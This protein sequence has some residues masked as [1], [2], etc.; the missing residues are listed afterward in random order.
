LRLGRPSDGESHPANAALHIVACRSFVETMLS[1]TVDGMP[2]SLGPAAPVPQF[3]Y[4]R[5]SISPPPAPGQVVV[6]EKCGEE[7]PPADC[8]DPPEPVEIL[9]YVA[10]PADVEAPP[11]AGSVALSH[12]YGPTEVSCMEPGDVEFHV[13]VTGLDQ[14][15]ETDVLYIVVLDTGRPYGYS[16]PQGSEWVGPDPVTSLSFDLGEHLDLATIPPEEACVTVT[17]M[18]LAGHVTPIAEICGSTPTNDPPSGTD[19]SGD[20][21]SGCVA[22]TTGGDVDATT[23]GQTP[24]GTGTVTGDADLDADSP[25]RGCACATDGPSAPSPLALFALVLLAAR[26]RG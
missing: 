13:E 16:D 6:I 18:D 2:A 22:S 17:A 8:P 20:G 4:G 21:D 25:A 26:R 10:G 24:A 15:S 5:V 12:T 3:S 1:V 23:T 11:V 9:R 19:S 7:A 14:G